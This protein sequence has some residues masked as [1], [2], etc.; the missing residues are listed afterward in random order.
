M[1]ESPRVRPFGSTARV[2]FPYRSYLPTSWMQWLWLQRWVPVNMP[3][4]WAALRIHLGHGIIRMVANYP[5]IV[6]GLVHPSFLSGHC[7]HKNPIY[8]QGCNPLRICG[9]SHQ[10][11]SI[12]GCFHWYL[13]GKWWWKPMDCSRYTTLHILGIM[14][15]SKK[16]ESL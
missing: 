6:S 8:N 16:G 7:P 3:V 11:P 14:S 1:G 13:V 9:M 12:N 15:Q 10:V 5:R 4:T 2:V